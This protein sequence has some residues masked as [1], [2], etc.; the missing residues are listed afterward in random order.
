[1]AVAWQTGKSL[2]SDNPS[3]LSFF[4]VQV[5][6]ICREPQK[7]EVWS[8]NEGIFPLLLCQESG[9][10]DGFT[11]DQLALSVE[12]RLKATILGP[13]ASKG[14]LHNS[15]FSRM[16][17]DDESRCSAIEQKRNVNF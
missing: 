16:A 6:K 15:S 4:L 9:R 7:L 8:A 14:C 3:N 12:V 10:T 17:G 13:Y 1:M 11:E 2:S 5:P